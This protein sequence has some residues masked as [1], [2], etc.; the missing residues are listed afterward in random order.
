M[1]DWL[2]HALTAAYGSLQAPN[3]AFVDRALRQRPYR[4]LVAAL[5]QVFAVE[6]ITDSNYDVSF[7]YVLQGEAA[8]LLHLSMVDRF[9]ALFPFSPDRVVGQALAN[10]DSPQAAVI[11]RLLSEHGSTVVDASLLQLR[12]GVRDIESNSG[13]TLSVYQ[14]LFTYDFS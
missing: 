10:A 12:T 7:A 1:L 11:L 5:E 2:T 3:Y 13:Q 9:A 6:D 8:Y 14:A 4:D